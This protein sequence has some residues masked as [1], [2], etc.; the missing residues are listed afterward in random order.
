MLRIQGV[1]GRNITNESSIRYFVVAWMGCLEIRYYNTSTTL[2]Y[3]YG[4][5]E[6]KTP[7]SPSYR[8]FDLHRRQI[9]Y[10]HKYSNLFTCSPLSIILELRRSSFITNNS[11]TSLFE[12]CLQ[13]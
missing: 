9:K 4:D 10:S 2:S 8:R 1:T 7:K 11:G 5:S 12:E 13:K 6:I 3:D